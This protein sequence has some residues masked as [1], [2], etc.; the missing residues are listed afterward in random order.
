ML[1]NKVSLRSSLQSL[2]GQK[3]ARKLAKPGPGELER[4]RGAMISCLPDAAAMG[5]EHVVKRLEQAKD[6]EA[7][8]FLRAD[9]MAALCAIEDETTA[10]R[11]MSRITPMFSGLLPTSLNSRPSPLGIER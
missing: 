10:R 6:I 7:L 3:P 9:L 4:V 11:T 8:W 1:W 5:Y 2:L